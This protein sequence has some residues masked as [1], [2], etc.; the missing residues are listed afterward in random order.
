MKIDLP[1]LTNFNKNLLAPSNEKLATFTVG[2]LPKN[3]SKHSMFM[4][5]SKKPLFYQKLRDR[6]EYL[7]RLEP[8]TPC[9]PKCQEGWC[10]DCDSE[11][12]I[13]GIAYYICEHFQATAT[14]IQVIYNNGVFT[15]GEPEV[16]DIPYGI[17]IDIEVGS[18]VDTYI[19]R[20]YIDTAI[21]AVTTNTGSIMTSSI[22]YPESL[23]AI[24]NEQVNPGNPWIEGLLDLSDGVINYTRDGLHRLIYCNYM[25]ITN[26]T[27]KLTYSTHYR[28]PK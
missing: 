13:Q 14:V 21:N 22:D 8:L 3:I 20:G 2:Q 26:I 9:D 27:E 10:W 11:S 25:I 5:T 1:S 19:G 12:C 7:R 4:T 15:L 18:N 17:W 24:Q 23:E 6:Y 16:V 28:R